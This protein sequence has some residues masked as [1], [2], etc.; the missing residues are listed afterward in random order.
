[1][2]D[3]SRW[4]GYFGD[5]PDDVPVPITR[6]INGHSLATNVVLSAADLGDAVS[7]TGD[8]MTGNLYISITSGYSLVGFKDSNKNVAGY[9]RT[10]NLQHNI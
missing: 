1:M 3:G 4:N 9:I 10:A 5:S 8:T 6:T 2:P 7:K